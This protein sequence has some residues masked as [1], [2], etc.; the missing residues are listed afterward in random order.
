MWQLRGR[1]SKKL[2]KEKGPPFLAFSIYFFF[3]GPGKS[4]A[5]EFFTAFNFLCDCVRVPLSCN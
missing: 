1:E 5:L 3:L 4:F 2:T